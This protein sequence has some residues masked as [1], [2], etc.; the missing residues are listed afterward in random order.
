MVTY[1]KDS[2]LELPER[3]KVIAHVA[4]AAHVYFLFN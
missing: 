3:E 4:R 2:E 1:V